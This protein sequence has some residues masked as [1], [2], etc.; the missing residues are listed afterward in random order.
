MTQLQISQNVKPANLVLMV[1]YLN[2]LAFC[3]LTLVFGQQPVG[4]SF[5]ELDKQIKSQGGWGLDNQRLSVLFNIGRKRL[6]DRFEPALLEY[7]GKD[8][9]KHYWVSAFLEASTYLQGAT[10]LP[11]L[12]L[13]IKQQALALLED[14]TDDESLSNKTRFSVTAAV[15]SE[16]LGLHELAITHKT[17]VEQ[18]LLQ[19][20]ELSASIPGMVD[21]ER[22]LYDSLSPVKQTPMA[23]KD[24]LTWKAEAAEMSASNAVPPLKINVSGGVLQEQALK[25]VQPLYPVEAR[26][27]GVSGTVKVQI[28]ISK[29]GRVIEATALDGPEQ[30][31]QAALDA[32]RQWTFK[33]V[34]LS[35]QAVRMSGVLS[36][37]FTLR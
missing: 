9:E 13:L 31:L 36:F 19:K 17:K 11:H 1:V 7:L 16:Q 21:E 23:K 12:S 34:T 25:K 37:N 33:P 30:L 18:L 2:I 14:K 5:A 22:K 10:P 8:V 6:G 3:N 24:L 28:L 29:E 20:P 4:A 35:G 32:A 15:L 27:A 26:Q